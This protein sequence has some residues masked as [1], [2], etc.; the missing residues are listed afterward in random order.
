MIELKL[1][2]TTNRAPADELV[3]VREKIRY[4]KD[5]EEFLRGRMLAGECSLVGDDFEVVI[6]KTKS[7]RLDTAAIKREFGLA[8]L[9]PFLTT[10]ETCFVKTRKRR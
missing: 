6:S 4:L 8:T 9:R 1:A 2:Q 7:E 3:D 10:V 5:R